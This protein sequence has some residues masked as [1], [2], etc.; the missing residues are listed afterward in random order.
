MHLELQ[1]FCG[2]ATL[3]KASRRGG[4]TDNHGRLTL[5][6]GQLMSAERLVFGASISAGTE[7]F[8]ASQ[9][10]LSPGDSSEDE[11]IRQGAA[12][13]TGAA[14]NPAR[15]FPGSIETGNG[16][17]IA[18]KHLRFGADGNAARGV[19]NRKAFFAVIKGRRVDRLRL[20]GH[21]AVKVLVPAALDGLVPAVNGSTKGRKG[22]LQRF[23]K[24]FQRFSARHRA[25]HQLDGER[26]ALIAL[27]VRNNP[28]PAFGLSFDSAADNIKGFTFGDEAAALGIE[29]DV[30][31]HE[32]GEAPPGKGHHFDGRHVNELGARGLRHQNAVARGTVEQLTAGVRGGRRLRINVRAECGNHGSVGREAPGGNDHC[33]RTDE[34]HGA[35]RAFGKNARHG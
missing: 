16:V 30:S 12:A 23:G 20:R 4:T 32:V 8:L 3:V 26:R 18:V 33:R 19:M 31:A 34:E 25:A 24:G 2:I 11:T 13:Q 5:W 15:C 29:L 1:A 14:M 10:R 9:R 28:Q 27:D 21:R 35:L 6:S 7:A 22:H 17:I